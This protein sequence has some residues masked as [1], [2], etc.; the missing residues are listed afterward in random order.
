MTSLET[1]FLAGFDAYNLGD[2]ESAITNYEIYI[3]SIEGETENKTIAQT[4]LS[5]AYN[6]QC[7][8]FFDQKKWT[9]A[10][11]Y[12]A[13]WAELYPESYISH[14]NTGSVYYNLGDYVN[15]YKY[16][17]T[18]LENATTSERISQAQES[19]DLAKKWVDQLMIKQNPPSND[20]L[21]YEQYYLKALNVPAAWEKITGSH[22]V[23]V[24]IIDDG[25]FFNHPDL[26]GKIWLDP[27]APYGVSKIIDFV[28][29]NISNYTAWQHWTMIAGII[30][31]EI[32]NNEGIA[33]IAKNVVFMP[34]RVFG[35]D[36]DASGTNIIQ[37]INYAID[38]GANIINLSLGW[39]QF[40]TYS[41][42]YDSVI[43]RAYDNGI[44]VVI[45]AGNGD[46]LARSQI[47]LDLSLNPISPVCNNQGST[48]YSTGIGA[49]DEEGRRTLWTNYN[50]CIAFFAPGVWI[51]ST[52]VSHFS[53]NNDYYS[54]RS[55]T[56]YAAPMIA[57]IVALGFNQYW[58]VSP[59]IVRA[60]L[61]ESLTTNAAWETVVDA[62]KYI[63]ALGTNLRSIQED[64]IDTDSDGNYLASLGIVK[65]QNS[66][67]GY[68][69]QNYVLRQ[70]VV[71]MAMKLGKFNFPENYIC[72][73]I[74]RDVSSIKPNNW[75]C[76]SVEI[77]ANK[78]IVS[79]FN[80]Y[81]NPESSITRAEALAILIKAAGIRIDTS[82]ST[83]KYTDVTITWQINLVNTA[84]KY[85]FI[86]G[87]TRFYPNSKATREEIFTMARKIAEF[88][89]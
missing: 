53:D 28:G 24:A 81:F 4:N 63:D 10:L 26:N 59:N 86:N 84:L 87:W 3:N 2:Y 55:W 23:V 52:S 77:A 80:K 12:C 8:V 85:A 79:T 42:K 72:K 11:K 32:N 41:D 21:S 9:E 48:K 70:E 6:A 20:P 68:N 71:W 83:S 54:T 61:N 40:A 88:R 39:N 34:L 19:L 17:T 67:A 73:R 22:E 45:A 50:S 58:Y 29:D 44:V 78:G 66:E 16:F 36:E 76:R 35:I 74:F 33:G 37:A 13:K 27:D 62:S 65:K 31:A 43:R 30:G 51:I 64:T 47:G 46:V 18:A 60:S 57:G 89:N 82:K 69:L 15:A 38:H 1:Y 49:S 14:Y 56:S 75:I 25:V 7:W 5:R